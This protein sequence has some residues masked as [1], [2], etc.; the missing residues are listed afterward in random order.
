MSKIENWLEIGQKYLIGSSFWS[1]RLRFGC[2]GIM[3]G[4]KIVQT[5]IGS[6]LQIC[7]VQ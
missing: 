1:V 4:A 5:A 7:V 6:C 2:N 3:L